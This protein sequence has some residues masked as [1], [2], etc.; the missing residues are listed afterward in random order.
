MIRG[1]GA[2]PG[3]R[4][5]ELYLQGGVTLDDAA[6][7]YGASS[8][9]TSRYLKLLRAELGVPA[10]AAAEPPAPG[11]SLAQTVY[12]LSISRGEQ[13]SPSERQTLGPR[14][15]IR[16]TGREPGTTG[17][18]VRRWGLT[19]AGQQALAS[20][21]HLGAAQRAVDSGRLAGAWR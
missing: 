21:P 9:A 17:G 16:E 5:A 7:R 15:W 10:R 6:A 13:P 18:M 2:P 11:P 1:P 12:L 14:G 8:S 19:D 20:S 4:A 3:R